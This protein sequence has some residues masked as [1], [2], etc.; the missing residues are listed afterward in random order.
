M[1]ISAEG[2]FYWTWSLASSLA[3]SQDGGQASKVCGREGGALPWPM[4]PLYLEVE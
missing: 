4:A 1:G 3:W 2:Q